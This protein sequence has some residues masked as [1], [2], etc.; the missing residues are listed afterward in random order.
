[1][2]PEKLDVQVLPVTA[3]QKMLAFFRLGKVAESPTVGDTNQFSVQK[4]EYIYSIQYIYTHVH[5]YLNTYQY[6]F[7]FFVV[8]PLHQVFPIRA[9]RSH[10]VHPGQLQFGSIT[11]AARH[12]RV[13]EDWDTWQTLGPLQKSQV[14]HTVEAWHDVSSC[15]RSGSNTE[16]EERMDFLL[17]VNNDRSGA[18]GK[19]SLSVH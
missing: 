3:L 11:T 7:L 5:V 16:W 8:H 18:E 13:R 10:T 12:G 19:S 2:N 17:Q 4:I 9:L 15:L 1:M 14:M 6:Q